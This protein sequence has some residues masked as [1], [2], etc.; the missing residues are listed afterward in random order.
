MSLRAI[1]SPEIDEDQGLHAVASWLDEWQVFLARSKY[2]HA[3]VPPDE[4][5]ED[6][7]TAPRA[8]DA[9]L[10]ATVA[11]FADETNCSSA[12]KLRQANITL[13]GELQHAVRGCTLAQTC[14]FP[15]RWSGVFGAHGRDATLYGAERHPMPSRSPRERR[16]SAPHSHKTQ[17][18]LL[19]VNMFFT[20]PPN[21]HEHDSPAPDSRR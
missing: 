7:P 10:A 17:P 19:T 14:P 6:F 8:G 11:A 9:D 20:H 3:L 5:P 21:H 1:S 18:C 4:I 16:L 12:T 13:Y 2:Y 15:G